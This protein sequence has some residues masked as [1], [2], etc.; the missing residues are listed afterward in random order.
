MA[1]KLF[2]DG[3]DLYE[4]AKELLK[5]GE[6]EKARNVFQKSIDK[7]GGVDD[8]AAIKI[9]L[10]DL[11]TR[12]TDPSAY[13]RVRTA[14]SNSTAT[15]FE[16][17]LVTVSCADLDRECELT[18]RK[19][20]LLGT[21]DKRTRAEGLQEVAVRFQSEIGDRN[22]I[23]LE[24]FRNDSTVTGM[25]EFFNLM[26]T[27]YETLSD[28]TVWDDPQKAAEY[29]QIAAGYRQQNG[30]SGDANLERIRSY[31][32]TCKCWICGRIAT[33]E[34]IHFFSAPSEVSPC[35]DDGTGGVGKSK[36][37]G[38]T[39]IY[40][41][42]ACYSAVSNRSDEISRKYYNDSIAE[43]RRTEARLQ[44]EIAALQSQISMLRMSR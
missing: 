3:N 25:T 20:E 41:C 43:I 33:G 21:S 29:E 30:Q 5:R 16:F 6:Y 17:G 12:L 26:A 39:H 10:I 27:S 1:F 11:R 23:V 19:L 9:A 8:V 38:T 7:D 4:D 28:L 34:G 15:E 40:I 36:P 13:G 24:L 31:A 18:K 35:L 2:K 22:L 42:R 32:R 44:A 37:E 14:I